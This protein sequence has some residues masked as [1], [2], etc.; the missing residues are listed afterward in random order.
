MVELIISDLGTAKMVLISQTIQVVGSRCCRKPLF[1]RSLLQLDIYRFLTEVY[2]GLFIHE[3]VSA[4]FN[5]GA[6]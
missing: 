4:L 2:L 3:G 1:G 5:R 6:G